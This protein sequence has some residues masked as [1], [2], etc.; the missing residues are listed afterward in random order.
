[1][2]SYSVCRL[3]HSD[4]NKNPRNSEGSFIHLRD[5][6]IGFFYSRYCAESSHDHANADIAVIYSADNGESWSDVFLAIESVPGDKIR[7]IDIQLWIDP[8]WKLWAF[9]TVRDD[10]FRN[11][12][13]QHLSVWAMVGQP[14]Q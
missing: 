9:W 1:M 8:D 3:L 4:E 5:G 12:D 10:N 11:D 13:P 14:C 6:R 2:K 7:A